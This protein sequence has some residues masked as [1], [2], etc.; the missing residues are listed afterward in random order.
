M[1]IF[2][3]SKTSQCMLFC[4]FNDKNDL[5]ICGQ[6]NS[7][8]IFLAFN[9]DK[10]VHLRPRYFQTRS[11]WWDSIGDSSQRRFTAWPKTRSAGA[12]DCDLKGRNCWALAR[13]PQ[14]VKWYKL[15]FKWNLSKCRYVHESSQIPMD[16]ID[17]VVTSNLL[18]QESQGAC[19]SIPKTTRKVSWLDPQHGGFYNVNPRCY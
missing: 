5:F 2:C 10:S 9:D 16:P 18:A 3:V 19:C 6:N 1:K 13:G 4:P 12:G 11:K 15:V 8:M 14:G 17:L 7:K